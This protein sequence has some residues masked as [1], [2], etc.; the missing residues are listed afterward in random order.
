VDLKV[1][2]ISDT[3][4]ASLINQH[5]NNLCTFKWV[6]GAFTPLDVP[7][8]TGATPTTLLQYEVG[9]VPSISVVNSGDNTYTTYR[10]TGV[11]YVLSGTRETLP[12]APV[13]PFAI[14]SFQNNDNRTFVSITN[15]TANSFTSYRDDLTSVQVLSSDITDN[16]SLSFTD[17]DQVIPSVGTFTYYIK[18]PKPRVYFL[19]CSAKSP[20]AF[21]TISFGAGGKN[22]N[23]TINNES[24]TVVI[25]VG[26]DGIIRTLSGSFNM[27]TVRL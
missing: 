25:F 9:G 8:V 27:Q 7:V 11:K 10:W 2:K 5:S 4:Y 17:Q 22:Q 26:S 24:G 20:F 21:V 23:I 1:Y 12:V 15:P 16:D 3:W 13:H 19:K 14:A 18:N 6:N